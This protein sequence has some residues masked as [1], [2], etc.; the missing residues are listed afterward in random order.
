[1]RNSKSLAKKVD[2]KME[3]A[4]FSDVEFLR[5]LN[6]H[7]NL[8][9]RMETLLNIAEASV[10]AGEMTADEAEYRTSIIFSG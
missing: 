7:P 8:R 10:E 2:R 1:L 6:R 4:K 5:C 9:A 3:E